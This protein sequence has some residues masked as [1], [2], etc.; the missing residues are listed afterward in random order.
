MAPYS[1]T[2]CKNTLCKN[3]FRKNTLWKLKS[4]PLLP[5][6]LHASQGVARVEKVVDAAAKADSTAHTIKTKRE[7]LKPKPHKQNQNEI[8]D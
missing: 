2:L 8:L 7:N 4:D 5:S 3:T 1:N 6:E